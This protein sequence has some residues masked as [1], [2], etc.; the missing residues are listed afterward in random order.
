MNLKILFINVN[1]SNLIDDFFITEFD[2]LTALHSIKNKLTR[3]NEKTHPYYNKRSIYSIIKL[4]L[5]DFKHSSVCT[6]TM[7]E[8]H[9]YSSL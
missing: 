4:I 9:H 1:K 3:T 5:Y 8:L 2:I 7:E 6:F